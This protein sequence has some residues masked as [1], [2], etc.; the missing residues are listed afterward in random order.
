VTGQ[1]NWPSPLSEGGRIL[2]TS[3]SAG[4]S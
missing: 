4:I 3:K 1:D 2:A